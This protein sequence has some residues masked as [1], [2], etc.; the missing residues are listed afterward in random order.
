MAKW[1]ETR[2]YKAPTQK[3]KIKQHEPTKHRGGQQV[4]RKGKNLFQKY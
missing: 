4:L 3:L 2:I 1:K